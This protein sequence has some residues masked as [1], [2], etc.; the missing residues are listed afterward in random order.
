MPILH[1]PLLQV[2]T[3]SFIKLGA[4]LPTHDWFLEFAFICEVHEY[5]FVC[6]CVHPKGIHLYDQLNKF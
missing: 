6:M 4:H 5:A 3:A 1:W 2:Y